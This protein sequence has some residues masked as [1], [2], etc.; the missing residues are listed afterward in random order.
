MSTLLRWSIRVG[1]AVVVLALLLWERARELGMPRRLIERSQ[2]HTTRALQIEP[3]DRWNV[4]NYVREMNG[5][6]Q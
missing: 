2:F 1:I 3:T 5:G 6:S 4:V